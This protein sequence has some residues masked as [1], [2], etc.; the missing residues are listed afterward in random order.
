MNPSTAL[1]RVL[2]D[3]LIACGLTDAVLAPGSRN[4]PLSLALHAAD[5]AGRVRLHVRIDERTAGFLALG[6]ARGSGRPVVVVTTSGTAV[7]NLHPA[8][9]EA[10]HG[11]VPLVV[12][13]ADRPP[14]LRGVGANQTID[15]RA[16]FGPA[17]RFFHEFGV[18]TTRPGQQAHWR[19][20]T[21]R[22][23]SAAAGSWGS[24]SG[25]AQL[26]VPL[27]EPLLPD[28]PD[29][30][31]VPDAPGAPGPGPGDHLALDGWP[32]PL[33]GRAGPW[34]GTVTPVLA[35]APA[36]PAPASGER[37]RFVAD[38]THPWASLVADAGHLVV[39]EAGGAAGG[40]ALAAGIHL[41]SAP[42]F[43]AAARPDRVIVLGRPTLFRP[44]Q[45]LLGDPR[46]TVDV[47]AHPAAY[48]DPSGT[49]RSVAPGLPD[50]GNLPDEQWAGRWREADAVAGRAVGRVID[51]LDLSAS[52][53]LVRDLVALLPARST[54]VVGSS[55]PPRDLALTA[56]PR[57]GLRLIANR[58][59]A[60]I[61]GTVSTAV[62]AALAATPA[63]GPTVAL[64]GDLTFLHDLTGLI[65]GPAE[66]RPELTIV[67]G[68]NDGGAIFGTLESGDP[69]H[70]PAFERVFGT[71]HGAELAAA[72][73]AFGHRYTRA[74]TTADLDAALR[75]R[76]GVHVVEVRTS[77]TDLAAVLATIGE[78]VR[79]AL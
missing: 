39:A 11:Q 71:P 56:P 34:T 44:V 41:L 70:A 57:D 69:A 63:D 15:Q 54:L 37:V 6:L 35:D 66:P 22:A 29:A 28:V 61:D 7:A 20:M 49:V 46:V 33:S 25:P 45:Q 24:P 16:L 67:V 31:A 74:G 68:N 78:A 9:L 30:G 42:G 27:T 50:L 62:G 10:A 13:S 5:A 51:G 77:R 76:G 48:A 64:L 47:V 26:N 58:G 1:A 4:A 73:T 38:L 75:N 79:G 55:Q 2:V 52:P 21:G 53:R 18:A 19:S 23:W 40:R 60:G 8:V 17:L 59:V 14:W 12:L 72:V 43:L 3:E 32:E 65:I 36:V